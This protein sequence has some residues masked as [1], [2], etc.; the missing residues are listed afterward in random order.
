M[1][2]EDF[3]RI[4]QFNSYKGVYKAIFRFMDK[5]TAFYPSVNI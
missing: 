4:S 1:G 2:C 3:V 5:N